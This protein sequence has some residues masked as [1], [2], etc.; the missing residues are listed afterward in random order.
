MSARQTIDE[1][2]QKFAH[3]IGLP[4][5]H[6][7][8]NELSLAFDDHLKVHFIFHPETN[9]LQLETEIVGLQIVNSDL[10]RSFLA[11]NYHWPEHQLFFSLDNHR[12]VLCLNKLIGIEQ[13]DYEYFENAL[14]ELL[15]QSESW[16]SLLS[17]H[18]VAE[19]TPAMP[20]SLD[21]RV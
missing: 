16:E 19:E 17:A 13:L 21:L 12:H 11:F 2:L 8:D 20:Q 6:L 14:A 1:V 3:Q 9:T 15:T 10:Y 5:L 4:E 7:T 18:V